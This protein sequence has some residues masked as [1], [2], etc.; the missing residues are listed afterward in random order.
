MLSLHRLERLIDHEDTDRL[1]ADLASNGAVIPLPVQVRLGRGATAALA[2]ALRRVTELTHGPTPLARRLTDDLLD[3]QTPE[4]GWHTDGRTDV[5]ATA[6]AA[7]AL[8]RRLREPQFNRH[9]EDQPEHA[10]LQL[11]HDAALAALAAGQRPEDG[12]FADRDDRSEAD[13]ALTSCFVLFLL[14]E[15]PAAVRTLRL[16]A[17]LDTLERLADRFPPATDQLWQ[18]AKLLLDH[19]PAVPTAPAETADL[20]HHPAV[21]A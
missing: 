18:M 8:G 20:F 21:A 19:T 10:R 16:T 13:R 11:A 1:L 9:P 14:A 12:L 3:A 4:G 15:N 5:L 6:A 2:L 17:L 7:A